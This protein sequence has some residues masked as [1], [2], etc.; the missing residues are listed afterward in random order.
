VNPLSPQD[1][2]HIEA[3]NA[4]LML[5]DPIDAHEELERITPPMRCHPDVLA[6]RY[7]AYGMAGKWEAAF[8]IARTL[9]ELVPDDASS[10]LKQAES[11][12]K[13]PSG[14][15]KA[16]LD[17]L[18]PVADRF[19]ENVPIAYSLARYSCQSGDLKAARRW[20]MRAMDKG[21]DN[22]KCVALDD[23]ELE[24]LWKDKPEI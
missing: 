5:D 6:M 9:V 8:E 23:K 15:A 16:T 17:S 1:Q 22:I 14:G 3:A 7:A 20:L 10:W 24:P 2:W 13:M 4:W 19:P 21:G 12:R 11:L 18:L